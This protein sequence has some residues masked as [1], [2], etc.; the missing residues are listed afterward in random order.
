MTTVWRRGPC[1]VFRGRDTQTSPPLGRGRY[2]PLDLIRSLIIRMCNNGEAALADDVVIL[3]DVVSCSVDIQNASTWTIAIQSV[4][5]T[6][7]FADGRSDAVLVSSKET[8][9]PVVAHRP[10]CFT[11]A[12]Q[13]L[14]WMT[15]AYREPKFS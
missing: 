4:N 8:R 7:C 13:V 6:R 2:S 3:I 15:V 1:I 11:R 10:C 9:S 12:Q 5:S 14:G